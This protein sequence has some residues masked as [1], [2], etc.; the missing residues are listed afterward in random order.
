VLVAAENDVQ[1]D[2]RGGRQRAVLTHLLVRD[3]DQQLGA[4]RLQVG[5]HRAGDADHLANLHVRSRVRRLLGLGRGET[6][7][8]HADPGQ[9]EEYVRLGAAER[10]T[11]AAIEDVGRDTRER[12]LAHALGQHGRAEVE[13][14][15]AE[16]GQ[17]Q[18][19]GVQSGD[20]LLAAQQRGG[21]RR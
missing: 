18:T 1:L 9:R 16:G 4:A 17:V 5:R 3:R 14:V 20:H 11:R 6:E 13:L 21:D 10:T 15:V 12:R 19:D 8:P 7:H 2:A